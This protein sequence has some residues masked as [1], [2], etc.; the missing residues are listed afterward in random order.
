MYNKKLLAKLIAGVVLTAGIGALVFFK[1][2]IILFAI[3]NGTEARAEMHRFNAHVAS[4]GEVA[5]SPK[6]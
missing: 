2:D 5:H 4:Y 6:E 3:T 1:G